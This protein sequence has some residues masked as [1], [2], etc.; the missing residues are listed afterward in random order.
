MSQ[1]Y[2]T[3]YFIILFNDLP[4]AGELTIEHQVPYKVNLPAHPCKN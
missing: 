4:K 2:D 1:N 3:F